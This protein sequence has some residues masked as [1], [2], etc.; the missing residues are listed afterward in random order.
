MPLVLRQCLLPGCAGSGYAAGAQV[1]PPPRVWREWECHCCSGGAFCLLPH[2]PPRA[3]GFRLQQWG[4]HLL[5]H[6]LLSSCP[7]A[8]EK[9]VS[10]SGSGAPCFPQ[11][12]NLLQSFSRAA[13]GILSAF[14]LPPRCV[15]GM[16]AQPQTEGCQLRRAPSDLEI[17][18]A[19]AARG[20]QG[21]WEV[22][23]AGCTLLLLPSKRPSPRSPF[24]N[25]SLWQ[26]N[27]LRYGRSEGI[28]GMSREG[29]GCGG[30]LGPTR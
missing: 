28:F 24:A 11:T 3:A 16:A 13:A 26:S 15:Q 29:K 8:E 30:V 5:L 2:T 17:R 22:S 21:A 19:L 7:T 9:L 18:P 10:A 20:G 23:D 4:P 12:R 6:R 25:L 27:E 14:P 1:V